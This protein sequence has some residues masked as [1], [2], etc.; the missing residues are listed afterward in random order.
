MSLVVVEDGLHALDTGVLVGG[1]V[2]L[3]GSLVPVKD[4][5][6]EGRD[7]V[8]TGLGGSDGLD[9]GEHEGEVAVDAM[10]R[11]ELA[12]G[13]DTFPCG[14]DLDQDAVLGDTHFLVEL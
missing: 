5:A 1:V 14:G 13:L 12:G 9:D 8:S 4:T 2:P 6:N 3:H 11:L 10:L 7:Q